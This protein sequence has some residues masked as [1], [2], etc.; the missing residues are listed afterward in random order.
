MTDILYERNEIRF[1]DDVMK[2][3]IKWPGGKEREL[4]VI[5]KCIPV[6]SGRYVE[7][8]VGGGA[9]FFD[10]DTKSCCINDKSEE[11]INLYMCIREGDKDL[12]EYLRMETEE[13]TAIGK[14]TDEH[15]S[16]ILDLYHQRFG[17][18]EFIERHNGFFSTLAAGYNDVFQW[19]LRKNLSNKISRSEKLEKE[20]GAIPDSDRLD[21]IESAIKSAYYMYLRYLQ[22]HPSG[23]SKGRQ[24]AIFFFVREYCYSSMFRYNRNGEFNVPY[25]GISYN[26]KDLLKKVDYLLSEEVRKKLKS[27]EIHCE[28]FES[29]LDGL[30]LTGDDFVF[31]DPPYDTEFSSYAKNEFGRKEQERLRDCLK[32]TPAKILLII[33]N[34]DFIYNLYKDDFHISSFS[35]KYAVSFMNRNDR[36]AEHLIITNYEV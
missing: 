23:I 22:N 18:C 10:T 27:A 5:R 13:F 14:F 25:G 31:L 9:V 20:S 4:P 28:D 6:H 7:P 17:I 34:T 15:V 19:E 33:K 32:G 11:L 30:K 16:D 36:N 24:A 12:S 8:F 26:R 1:T 2:T 35:K 3:F 21:N 29:F